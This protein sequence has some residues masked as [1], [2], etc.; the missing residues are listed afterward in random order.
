LIEAL[1]GYVYW[2]AED[3]MSLKDKAADQLLRDAILEKTDCNR[4]VDIVAL[5]TASSSTRL[6][7]PI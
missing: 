6:T 5:L 1:T 7:S 3:R 4:Q 2:R